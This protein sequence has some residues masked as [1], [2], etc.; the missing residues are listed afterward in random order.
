MYGAIEQIVKWKGAKAEDLAKW[1]ETAQPG[2][3]V[4]HMFYS[5]TCLNAQPPTLYIWLSFLLPV[6]TGT[7]APICHLRSTLEVGHMLF[8]LSEQMLHV[9]APAPNYILLKSV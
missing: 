8:C 2:Q 1:L 7:H 4:I 9:R 3:N 5:R 6:N